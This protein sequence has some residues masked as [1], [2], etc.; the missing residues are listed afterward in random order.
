[1]DLLPLKIPQGYAMC[2]N[3][4]HDVEPEVGEDGDFLKNWGYFTEDLLQIKKMKL[5]AGKWYIPDEGLLID[6][7]WYPDSS[8]AGEYR[9]ELVNEKWE[10]H[11]EFS[12]RDRFLIRDKLEEW[13]V[14]LVGNNK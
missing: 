4:F 3:K 9:L 14:R 2:Y 12:S 7:G 13:L 10:V 11:D 6:L 1:L 8:N 5:K